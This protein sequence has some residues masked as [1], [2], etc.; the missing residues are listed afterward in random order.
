MK[1]THLNILTYFFII[2]FSSPVFIQGVHD[3][4][5][6]DYSHE[7]EHNQSTGIDSPNNNICFI[8][9]FKY[10]Q[11]NLINTKPLSTIAPFKVYEYKTIFN[12]PQKGKYHNFFL[13]RAPPK[14]FV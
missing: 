8:H 14:A 9:G 10:Y 4:F 7:I 3:A 12:N 13:L 6:H 11:Y 2:V 5:F 1:N